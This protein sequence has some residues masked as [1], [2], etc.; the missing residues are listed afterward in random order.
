M[1]KQ[2][3]QDVTDFILIIVLLILVCSPFILH[4]L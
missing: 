2:Y 3:K 4:Y 1:D